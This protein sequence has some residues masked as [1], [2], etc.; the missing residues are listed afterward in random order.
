MYD[1]YYI[2]HKK[3]KRKRK[4]NYVRIEMNIEIM[5]NYKQ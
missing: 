4:F 2:R 1:E 5:V 3:S